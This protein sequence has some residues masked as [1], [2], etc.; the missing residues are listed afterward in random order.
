M[1]TSDPPGPPGLQREADVRVPLGALGLG[2]E[3]LC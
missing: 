1:A 3:S 2:G